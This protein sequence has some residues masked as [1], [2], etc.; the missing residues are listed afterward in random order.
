MG[1]LAETKTDTMSVCSVYLTFLVIRVW[2]QHQR[3][4]L[5]ESTT[6]YIALSLCLLLYFRSSFSLAVFA[7]SV[8]L[9]LCFLCV[10]ILSISLLC[11]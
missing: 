8:V 6:L 7:G 5:E 10:N 4:R 3:E 11:P 2:F 9:A 1:D